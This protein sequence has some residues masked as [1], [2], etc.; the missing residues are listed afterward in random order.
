MNDLFEAF[1]VVN[2]AWSE[3]QPFYSLLSDQIETFFTFPFEMHFTTC[4]YFYL[5]LLIILTANGF[6]PCGSVITIRDNTK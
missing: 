5:L 1:S 6:L 2:C 4:Y 3:A